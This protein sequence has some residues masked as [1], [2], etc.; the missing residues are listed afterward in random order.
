MY[1]KGIFQQSK[2]RP[3]RIGY[4]H[5]GRTALMMRAY[6][7]HEF[8]RNGLNVKFYSKR[9]YDK[10]YSLVPKSITEFNS[11]GEGT[12][13]KAKGT[14]LID[15]IIKG[16][17]D[18]AMVGESSFVFC[19]YADKP[20][21]AIAEL[22]H[23]VKNQSGHVFLLRK[24]LKVNAPEDY[25]GKILVSRRAGP[26]DSIFLK[27]YLENEGINLKKDILQLHKLPSNLKEKEALPKDK[28]TIVDDLY[29]DVMERGIKNGVIDGGYFHLMSVPNMLGSFDIIRPL[30]NW[31]NPELSHALLVCSKE[32]LRENRDRLIALLEVYIKR[33]KYEHSLSYG[34]RTKE[35]GKGQQIA[36]NIFGLN[37][38][39]YDIIPT[40]NID[41]LN[42]VARLLRKYKFIGENN[43]KIDKFVDNGLVLKAVE[44]LGITEKDDYRKSEY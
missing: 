16:K 36:A 26:G 24:N 39:Q 22:G 37:Y 32:F 6:E 20:I 29:E 3:I 30:Q 19:I 17:F 21:V 8:E 40:V 5:G 7:N 13:G 4:F 41:L 34:E 27:E 23:D 31:S 44:N 33:I 15:G 1:I 2:I 42:E 18:L 12:V 9:L 11:E 14:E 38:P 25:L 43:V 28:V 35:G 10:N